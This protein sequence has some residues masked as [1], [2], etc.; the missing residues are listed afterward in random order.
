MAGGIGARFWPVS[1]KALPKQFLHLSSSGKSF[2]RMA[3]ERFSNI[4]P[5][6]NILVVTQ[7]RY[8]NLVTEEIPEILPENISRRWGSL[9]TV[10]RLSD[11]EV[12]ENIK[13]Q[14]LTTPTT[15]KL[16]RRAVQIDAYHVMHKSVFLSKYM[17]K[18]LQYG[19][20]EVA[21]RQKIIGRNTSGRILLSRN[22]RTS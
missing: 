10:R 7:S 17:G 12:F 13:G 14:M 18:T 15:K 3:Y 16:L 5:A 6:E 2:I 20:H 1:R 4:I 22:S 21:R 9:F 19:Y 11:G 8:E